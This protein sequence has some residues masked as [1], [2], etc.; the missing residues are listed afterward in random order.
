MKN[1]IQKI[2]NAFI[3]SRHD[4]KLTKEVHQWL[5]DDEHAGE[6][7]RALHSLWDETEG[8]ADAGTWVS[9]DKVYARIGVGHEL[10]KRYLL[11]IWR[12]VAAV[13]A[14]LIITASGTY[15]LTRKA[16]E[17]KT[18]AMVEKY[19]P[20][21][22]VQVVDLP[23]GSQVHVNSG[24]LLLYP[25]A[26]KGDTRTVYLIGEANF[27][28]KKD[29]EKPFIVHAANVSITA[30]GTEFNVAAYPENEE[31]VATLI[32]GKVKV[33]CDSLKDSYILTPGQQ[34]IYDRKNNLSEKTYA[35]LEDVT[36]WQR[37]QIVFRGNTM[38]EIVSILEK[39]FD[40]RIQCSTSLFTSDKY[41]FSFKDDANLEEVME[42]MKEVTERFTYKIDKKTCYMK[43]I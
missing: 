19:T 35:N 29:P 24:T 16:F 21:G 30:L 33:N 42:V 1:Y 36:A 27:K 6:K 31:I 9:L 38:Q 11:P 23:D 40:I 8:K 26:F 12:S 22:K 5:V 13:A 34:V 3:A 25:E 18:I 32:H 4:E 43:S 14:M 2:I 28:V 41:N 20:D 17:E 7:N 10:K 37:G 39:R 15:L